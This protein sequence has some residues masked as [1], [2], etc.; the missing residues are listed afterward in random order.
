M[1]KE[2]QE[3]SKETGCPI[4][5]GRNDQVGWFVLGCGQGA[6]VIWVESEADKYLK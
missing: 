2:C 5:I 4:G 3:A 6:F 1:P